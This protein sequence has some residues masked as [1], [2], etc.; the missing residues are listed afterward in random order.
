MKKIYLDYS[1]TTPISLSVKNAMTPYFT[2]YFANA[3]SLYDWGRQCAY[4]VDG[5]RRTIASLISAK[6]EEIFFTSGGSESDN[7][8]IKGIA[9][10]NKNKGNHIITSQIEH[11]AVMN[12]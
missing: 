8:A 6:P 9:F 3:D 5:A 10:A 11:P 2:E 4:A 12:T 7:W 1:A